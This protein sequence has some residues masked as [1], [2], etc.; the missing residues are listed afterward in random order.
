MSVQPENP[1]NSTKQADSFPVSVSS[2]EELI[3]VQFI[4]PVNAARWNRSIEG[5]YKELVDKLT[6]YGDITEVDCDD[7]LELTLSPA[8]ITARDQ[9]LADF[10]VL[11]EHGAAPSINLLRCYE[12]DP[13]FFPTDVYSFHVDRSPLATD[14]FLCTYY[15]EASD[16]LPNDEAI[17]KVNDPAIRQRL[18]EEYNDEA[19]SF[20]AYL[21]EAFY[22]L[23]YLPLPHAKP[24]NLGLGNL[25]RLAVDQPGSSILP[26]I[27]RAPEEKG[28][29]RLMLIC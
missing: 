1:Q 7:L 22:D 29:I 28:V 5:D 21:E 19:E 18:L 8:G 24:I 25:S 9:V 13:S 10:Q 11:E 2:F 12:R 4:G 3:A 26:S 17:L 20:E 15:G 16:I 6:L 27:H 14:T 23:H